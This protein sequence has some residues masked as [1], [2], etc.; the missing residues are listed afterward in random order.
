MLGGVVAGS[1]A[2]QAATLLFPPLRRLL[3]LTVPTAGDWALI[4]GSA[5]A[6]V[7]VNEIRRALRPTS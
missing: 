7:I 1:L 5:T 3:G 4:A 2:F 6:P